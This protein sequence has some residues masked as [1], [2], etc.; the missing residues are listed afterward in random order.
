MEGLT[1]IY[2][3]LSSFPPT[4]IKLMVA[5]VLGGLLGLERE[6]KGK[7]VGFTTCVIISVASCLL[8]NTTQGYPTIYVAI[9]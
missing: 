8:T 9:P 7:P 4:L 5:F 2:E 6:A 3:Q 1:Y